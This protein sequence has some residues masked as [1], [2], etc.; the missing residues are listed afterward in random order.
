MG[1]TVMD[2]ASQVMA[3]EVAQY[4][5]ERPPCQCPYCNGR[6][7]YPFGNGRLFLND[8]GPPSSDE[9]LEQALQQQEL[10]PVARGYGPVAH[11][12]QRGLQ[13]A[14][15]LVAG[16]GETLRERVL[17][18]QVGQVAYHHLQVVQQ[19]AY[20]YLQVIRQPTVQQQIICSVTLLMGMIMYVIYIYFTLG[21]V[22]S[23]VVFAL[24]SLR[25]LGVLA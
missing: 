21:P 11:R 12:M 18:T 3:R 19:V 24:F 16:A 1:R 2:V 23:F 22:A 13:R 6:H 25:V 7:P 20:H 4:G 14:Q 5:N 10:Q 8:D 15:E 17:G 9:E